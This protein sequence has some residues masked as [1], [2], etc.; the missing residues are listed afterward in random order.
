MFGI[1]FIRVGKKEWLLYALSF[2]P[3]LANTLALCIALGWSE[4]R[5]VWASMI[6]SLLLLGYFTIMGD[7]MNLRENNT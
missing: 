2:I 1:L 4:F 6:I 7:K 5:F 3:I